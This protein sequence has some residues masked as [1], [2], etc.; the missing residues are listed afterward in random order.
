LK[1]VLIVDDVAANRELIREALTSSQY[2]F[3]EAENA[4]D[5]LQ[6]MRN[7]A[8]DLVITDMR[9][10]GV[11]GVDLLKELQSHYPN[12]VVIL[13][14]AFATV[15]SA[16]AAMKAGA[17]DY[18]TRPLDLDNLELVV[19]RALDNRDF[20]K[21]GRILRTPPDEKRGFENMLGHSH[22][23]LRTLEQAR[24]A[25][26]TNSTVLIQGETGTG[27]E[28]LARGIH[29]NSSRSTKPFITLNCSAIPKELLESELFGHVK[30][31]FTSALVDRKGKAEAAHGG[32]LFLDEIG[33]MPLE[34]Q[35]KVLRLIQ[36]GEIEKV[37]AATSAR[38]DIRVVAATHRNL[39]VMVE[40]GTFRE[41]LYYRLNVIP[42]SLPSLSERRDDIPELA[43]FF[44]ERSCS[45]HERKDLKLPERLLDSF[46]VYRWPGNIRELENIV[47]RLVVLTPGS[48]ISSADLPAFL[49]A[50]PTPLEAISLDLPPTGISF[51]GLEK[52]VLLR[53]LQECNWNQ[54]KAARYL[55]LSRQT[56]I[57]RMQKYHLARRA[58]LRMARNQSKVVE[59]A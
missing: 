33:E 26:P 25:A 53:A 28:L 47:E 50:K 39:T 17:R 31:S 44:F 32:T 4:S 9:M 34:L 57:Y 1:E 21:Q 38:V 43:R 3:H 8:A 19:R 13:V 23:L 20:R 12:T 46:V 15:E 40:N 22:P 27:K 37:G 11:S 18:I 42:L 49:Q 7:R 6:V 2:E 24:R 48:E 51:G 36:Q 29:A 56:L 59:I 10:P 16:V 58:P 35:P 30:G 41:D 45:K 54:S 52:E 5:A 14:T 55:S